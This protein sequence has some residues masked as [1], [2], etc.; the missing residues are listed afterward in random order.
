ML[1][2]TTSYMNLTH[3]KLPEVTNMA[4]GHYAIKITTVLYSNLNK[5]KVIIN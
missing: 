3:T 5:F 2:L 1:E 4:R